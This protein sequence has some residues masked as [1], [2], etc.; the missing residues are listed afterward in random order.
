M[1]IGP[2]FTYNWA[3]ADAKA[4]AGMWARDGD[5]IHPNG[6]IERGPE[7]I[8]MNRLQ[9]FAQREY[10][11]SKHPLTLTM[12]RCPTYD[13]AVADGVWSMNGVRNAEG[14]ELSQFEGQ[15]T[16]VA[17]RS[18]DAWRIEAYRYTLKP[19]PQPMPVWLTRP[20]WPDK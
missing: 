18:D 2:A 9:L 7:I 1:Q 14:K 17:R 20:G 16:I 13:I 15:V 6:D 8:M 11:G 19:P 5:I 10:R 3:T 4:L 12:V